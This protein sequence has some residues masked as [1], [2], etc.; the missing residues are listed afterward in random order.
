MYS[1]VKKT[2]ISKIEDDNA[3]ARLHIGTEESD[4]DE[5]EEEDK[6]AELEDGDEDY[7]QDEEVD[8]DS[9]EDTSSLLQTK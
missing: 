9:D 6:V 8:Y 4:Q 1:T 3:A 7:L 5:D 2:K